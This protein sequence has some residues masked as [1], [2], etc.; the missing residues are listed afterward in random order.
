M[1]LK[2]GTRGDYRVIYVIVVFFIFL[3]LRSAFNMI[4]WTL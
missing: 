4:T 2:V 3:G 1:W